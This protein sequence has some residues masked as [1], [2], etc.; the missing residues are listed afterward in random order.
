MNAKVAAAVNIPQHFI[1]DSTQTDLERGPVVD[2][3]GYVARDVLGNGIVDRRIQV[4]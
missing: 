3:A 4:L 1:G 2:E